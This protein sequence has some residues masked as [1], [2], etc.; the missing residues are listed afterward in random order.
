MAHGATTTVGDGPAHDHAP[1][2][3]RRVL[4]HL[5]TALSMCLLAA[6]AAIAMLAV[7]LPRVTGATPLTVLT[8]SMEP[9]LA[10]GTLIVV[11]PVDP[12]EIRPGDVLTY[13]IEPGDP[14][15]VTHRVVGL[16]TDSVSAS[17]TFT[18][19]GDGNAAPDR[20]PVVA[21]QVRGRLWYAVPLVGWVNTAV[22][23][24]TRALLVP[25]VA[26]AL[27]AYCGWTLV[28]AAVGAVGPTPSPVAP[29]TG[30]RGSRADARPRRRRWTLRW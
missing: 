5:G 17:R 20:R 15:L 19:Q 1:G 23:A 9:A 16:T 12:K 25:V 7:V 3:D 13:Q 2:R 26:I 24:G 4:R 22:D 6:V 18:L 14:A 8:S 28:G 27:L 29:V 10:P 11:R 21:D 30:H